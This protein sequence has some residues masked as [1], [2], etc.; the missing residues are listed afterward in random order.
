M[1]GIYIDSINIINEK[2][3]TILTIIIILIIMNT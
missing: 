1:S 2:R 3:V